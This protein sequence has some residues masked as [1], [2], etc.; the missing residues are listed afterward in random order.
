M[1]KSK[2]CFSSVIILLILSLTL[3]GCATEQKLDSKIN[4][5]SKTIRQATCSSGFCKKPNEAK[6]SC[7]DNNRYPAVTRAMWKNFNDTNF[8]EESGCYEIYGWLPSP[9]FFVPLCTWGLMS[10]PFISFYLGITSIV[11]L[12]TVDV[13]AIFTH[14]DCPTVPKEKEP[15]KQDTK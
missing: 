10:I 13:I 9:Y 8:L 12:P 7:E 3:D 2:Y 5:M 1:N 15:K 4:Q 11:F 6:S 14:P